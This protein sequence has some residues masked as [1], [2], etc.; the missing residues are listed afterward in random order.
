ME[1][2]GVRMPAT[3]RMRVMILRARYGDLIG[4]Y[5]RRRTRSPGVAAEVVDAV[6]RAAAD[7][8]DAVPVDALPWLLATARHECADAYRAGRLTGSGD[9]GG[10]E[11]AAAQQL[12]AHEQGA[13]GWHREKEDGQEQED[14]HRRD[15]QGGV[16]VHA[17]GL[18]AVVPA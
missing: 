15:A 6:F 16:E 4:L 7:R 3:D 13:Q 10:E 5:V 9:A 18:G 2:M 1:Q 17:E 11:D 12:H 14:L 8:W